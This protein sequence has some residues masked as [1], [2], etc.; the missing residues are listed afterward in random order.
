[1]EKFIIELPNT[2]HNSQIPNYEPDS[3]QNLQFTQMIDLEF[4]DIN[5]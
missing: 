2:A 1:M 3:P 4:S 5:M